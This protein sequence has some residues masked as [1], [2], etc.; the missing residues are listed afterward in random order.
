MDT[1]SILS[2]ALRTYTMYAWYLHVHPGNSWSYI[3]IFG[4]S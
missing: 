3:I 2:V 4:L 1:L